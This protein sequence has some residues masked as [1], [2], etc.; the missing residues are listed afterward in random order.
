MTNEYKNSQILKGIEQCDRFINKESPRCADLRPSDVQETLDK[1]IAHKA[2]LNQ[3]LTN[4]IL[5]GSH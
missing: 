5:T 3:M 2:K 1:T 4:Y